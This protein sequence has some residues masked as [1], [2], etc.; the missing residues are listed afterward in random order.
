MFRESEKGLKKTPG[1]YN[2]SVKLVQVV[3][4]TRLKPR[5]SS[6]VNLESLPIGKITQTTV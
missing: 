5:V 1:G 3:P 4:T 2:S 6:I